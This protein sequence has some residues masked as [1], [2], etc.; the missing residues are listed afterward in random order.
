MNE[1]ALKQ[2]M[3]QGLGALKAGGQ[4]GAKAA[5]D[6]ESDASN[7]QLKQALNQGSQQAK[8][9]AERIDR[10]LQ[11]VGGSDTNDNPVLEAHYEVAKRIRAEA[12]DDFS[13]DLGIIA[14]SQL[15]LHYW[16]ASFGTMRAYA[17]RADLSQTQ[18]EMAKCLEEA[19][20]ADKQMTDLAIEIM[21]G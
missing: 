2:L 4:I 20:Q 13:R 14:A 21:G 11:E 6:I 7:A 12:P 8:T 1:Q 18:Q 5:D 9:W 16:I 15:A 19:E 3:A 10:A 17:K